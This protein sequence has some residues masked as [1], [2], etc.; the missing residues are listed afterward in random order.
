MATIPTVTLRDLL[1]SWDIADVSGA[2]GDE[3]FLD[4]V[5]LDDFN[6]TDLGNGIRARLSL[7]FSD[8]LGFQF[9]GLDCLGLYFGSSG[10]TNVVTVECEIGATVTFRLVN[11]GAT[12]RFKQALL[13]RV[14]AAQGGGYKPM[15]DT[16]GTPLA[17][18][19][20]LSGIDVVYTIGG[21]LRIET[22]TGGPQLSLPPVMIADTGV[23]I[24]S[25]AI[26]LHLSRDAPPPPGAAAGFVGVHIASA[27]VRLPA[28][29]TGT[30]PPTLSFT[31][32]R[33]GSDGF[34]GTVAATN[35]G[36]SGKLGSAQF[37]LDAV[38][39]TFE[40]N[41]LTQSV[42]GGSLTLPFF[43]KPVGL[44][45]GIAANGGVLVRLS[46]VNGV[47]IEKANVAKLT[48][49]AIALDARTEDV[50]VEISGSLQP[51]FG[52]QQWPIIEVSQ[53]RIHSDG[54]VELPG[55]WIV[56]STQKTGALSGF[57]LDIRKIGFGSQGQKRWVGFSGGLKLIDGMPIGASVEGLKILWDPGHP[58]APPEVELR[59][60]SVKVRVPKTLSIDAS[61]S[62]YQEGDKSIFRG[63]G[64]L[65]LEALG[66]TLDA[67]LLVG[68]TSEFTFFY[69]FVE[70]GLPAGIPLA[71][72]GLALYGLGGLVGIN[73]APDRRDGE[74][75]YDG[76]YKRDPI[77][78]THSTKWRDAGGRYAFGASVT[79]GTLPDNGQAMHGRVLVIVMVPGPVIMIEG[80]VNLV[81]DRKE[82]T[83]TSEPRF[84]GLAIID[85]EAGTL[86][87]NLEPRFLVP[88][89]QDKPGSMVDVTGMAEAFFDFHHGDRWYLNIGEKDPKERRIRAKLLSLFDANAYVMVNQQRLA[90]GAMIGYDVAYNYG[91]VVL[92][93]AFW[94]ETDALLVFR[95]IQFSADVGLHGRVELKVFGIGIAIALDA[96]AHLETPEPFA[97]KAELH[98]SV[99][100][101][102]PLP[103]VDFTLPYEYK[104]PIRPVLPVPLQQVDVLTRKATE[105]WDTALQGPGQTIPLDARPVL[106][107]AKAVHDEQRLGGN[108]QPA[109]DERSGDLTLS[110]HLDEV[111]VERQV[112]GGWTAVAA[113]PAP[114]GGRELFGMWLPADTG[115]DG[116]P[117]SKLQLFAKTP[118]EAWSAS[119]TDAAAEAF[120]AANP[121]YPWVYERIGFDGVAAGTAIGSGG[122]ASLFERLSFD[123]G[124]LSPVPKV[125][126][127]AGITALASA[128]AAGTRAL[129]LPSQIGYTT[130]GGGGTSVGGGSAGTGAPRR[131]TL[132]ISFPAAYANG[133]RSVRLRLSTSAVLTAVARDAA[134]AALATRALRDDTR[135]GLVSL[136]GVQHRTLVLTANGIR[137][138]DL[139]AGPTWIHAVE[140][141]PSDA[142]ASEA[143]A[144]AN[145]NA[146]E[147]ARWGEEEFLFEPDSR[148]RVRV[149]CRS[150]AVKSY[151]GALLPDRPDAGR[152]GPT[153]LPA[154]STQGN[155]NDYVFEQTV[156]LRTEGAPG[157][158]GDEID[159]SVSGGSV[160]VPPE[161]GPP[162]APRSRMRTLQAYI[163]RTL[164]DDPVRPFYRGYD[165]RIAFDESYIARMYGLSGRS[166][167]LALHD[168]NG[169]APAPASVDARWR[170]SD[171]T[172]L[173]VDEAQWAN[174]AASGGGPALPNASRPAFD[175]LDVSVRS[176]LLRPDTVYTASLVAVP[177]TGAVDPELHRFTLRCSRYASFAQHVGAF[178]GRADPPAALPPALSSADR[179]RLIAA[180]Q[181]A[182]VDDFDTIVALFG[183][184][185]SVAPQALRCT[186]LA[187][188]GQRWG[189]LIDSPEPFD[190]DRIEIAA[191]WYQNR[192]APDQRGDAWRVLDVHAGDRNGSD[193]NGEWID[194]VA[195]QAGD[196]AGCRLVQ[197][198]GTAPPTLL[199]TFGAGSAVEEGAVLRLHAGTVPT[200]APQDGRLNVYTGAAAWMLG[201]AESEIRLV[202]ADNVVLGVQAMPS[203]WVARDIHVVWNRDR[204]RVA[205]LP[206]ARPM[207]CLFAGVAALPAWLQQIVA[208]LAAQP[209]LNLDAGTW[210]FSW[211][212]RADIRATHAH[213]PLLR[214]QGV[215]ADETAA[216]QV[217]VN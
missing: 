140:W 147:T 207:G 103:D 196:L 17:A 29:L 54:R 201:V 86:Q 160:S 76:W 120:A 51:L 46:S 10:S 112:Q 202:G 127:T 9:P 155:A 105:S 67:Q 168:G 33:I 53:L 22:P 83:P 89:G 100:L 48:I 111:V 191:E 55:G 19:I 171:D 148:Y 92:R 136:R 115:S 145:H 1:A 187:D 4:K 153:Q 138:V 114:P 210:R 30:T 164:P 214:R 163:A 39:L 110:Y 141:V 217:R 8:E 137:H 126:D 205:V 32:A 185:S 84:R 216:M 157:F 197:L 213:S 173:R 190:R 146:G 195:L 131:F 132:R 77:G 177:A 58:D 11:V 36:F 69:V 212:H 211:R 162:K 192:L 6:I 189:V 133:V 98:L 208:A 161:A 52:S 143:S 23:V 186:L 57:P 12:L 88:D 122:S 3:S 31:N 97:F 99:D 60:V 59:G 193:F 178:D 182:T 38:A 198:V 151:L 129:W 101:P 66:L 117:N 158:V 47:S 206:K 194:L 125:V 113:R 215:A 154:P 135:T 174:L 104:E 21:S 165:I 134:G 204:T 18:Q 16:D 128:R 142:S 63:S 91:P 68:R 35:L 175:V 199:H 81:K 188:A 124:A 179:S 108:V 71:S 176:P 56:L 109:G 116:T 5:G 149:R 96:T 181:A 144:L 102:W 139:D 87:V 28:A 152:L 172:P 169:D 70:A 184:G 34:T 49:K 41:V 7:S 40:R 85:G 73:V 167:T 78:P 183:L 106:V 42:I 80:R 27:A 15:L 14:A 13:R 150:R 79:M 20:S 93:L 24:E 118:F 95:P 61:I 64:T 156:Y 26:T 203:G 200:A 170:K 82:M 180:A 94:F 44:E 45:F 119:S 37:S 130:A 107:F 90:F 25:Q 74:G 121:G 65:V 50:T 123:A 43:D 166:L 62:F 2:D 72:T 159:R 75:W 209:A